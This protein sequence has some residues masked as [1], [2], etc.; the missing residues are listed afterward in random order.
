MTDGPKVCLDLFCGLGGFSQAFADAPEWAVVTVDIAERFK[1]DLCAD[2]LDLRPADI[3]AALPVDGWDEL[4]AFVVLASPP[5]TEFSLAASRYEKIVDGKPQTKAA[6]EAVTLVYHTI[7]LIR[8]M[9]PDWWYLENPKGY[10]RQIIGDPTGWVTYCQYGEDYMKPTD[11]WGNHPPAFEYRRCKFGDDCHATNTD[12]EHGGLGN[13]DV[14]GTR[15]PAERAKVP[16]ELS[17]A[18]LEAVEQPGPETKQLTA[19]DYD[20]L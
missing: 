11:L 6:R 1:P 17:A 4:G 12:G 9:N 7:G 20:M 19:E 16:A 14:T 15:D 10:L 8:G 18:I 3:L 13:L 5:C 2:V